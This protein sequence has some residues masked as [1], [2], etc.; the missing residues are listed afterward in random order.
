M[1]SE[2]SIVKWNI[3]DV[4][5]MLVQRIFS[6][7]GS[8]FMTG[9]IGFL[10][11]ILLVSGLLLP[12]FAVGYIPGL[13]TISGTAITYLLHFLKVFGNGSP[14]QGI[15]VLAIVGGS[16]AMLFDTYNFL[17]TSKPIR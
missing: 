12:A 10:A 8:L 1:A 15:C 9:L 13:E 11:P 5:S 4:G 17:A 14:I 6:L 3:A 2:S 16:V 7:L